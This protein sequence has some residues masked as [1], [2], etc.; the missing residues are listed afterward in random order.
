MPIIDL[1][2]EQSAEDA[3]EEATPGI[4]VSWELQA[5]A[6]SIADYMKQQNGELQEDSESDVPISVELQN[7]RLLLRDKVMVIIGGVCK[8]HAQQ[9]LIK[10]LQVKGVRWL[11]A[12]KQDQVSD[13]KA[14]LTGAAVVVLITKNHGTQ[15]QRRA[16]NV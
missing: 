3:T 1:L 5:V 11:R 8:P 4:E 10:S 16:G 15:A 13:F 2:P 12:R 14:K 6:E 9:R 7:A